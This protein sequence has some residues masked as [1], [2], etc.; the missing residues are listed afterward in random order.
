LFGTALFGGRIPIPIETD[1]LAN[2][3]ER[4]TSDFDRGTHLS[5]YGLEAEGVTEF[6]PPRKP[7]VRIVAELAYDEVRQN[8]YRTT[9]RHEYRHVHFHAHLFAEPRGP[10]LLSSEP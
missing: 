2:L 8:R 9:L 3:I 7:K 1:Q 6:L 10:D 5:A 4:D